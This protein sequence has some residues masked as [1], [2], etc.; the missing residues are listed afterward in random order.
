MIVEN[1]FYQIGCGQD[2]MSL[3]LVVVIIMG[4]VF[5]LPMD[6]MGEQA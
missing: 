4:F 2:N 1:L 3:G 6:L 5:Q